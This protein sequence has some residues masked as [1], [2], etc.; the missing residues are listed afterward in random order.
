MDKNINKV[1]KDFCK[2]YNYQYHICHLS[3]GEREAF[4][5]GIL[6]KDKLK[7]LVQ[8]CDY[9]RNHGYDFAEDFVGNIRS[10]VYSDGEMLYSQDWECKLDYLQSGG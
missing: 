3:N 7:A 9:V 2:A 10:D 6:I 5:S 8:L 4:C 1:V